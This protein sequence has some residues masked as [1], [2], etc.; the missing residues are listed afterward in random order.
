MR[1][2]A[3]DKDGHPLHRSSSLSNNDH[4]RLCFRHLR[5]RCFLSPFFAEYLPTTGFVTKPRILAIASAHHARLLLQD[6]TPCLPTADSHSQVPT[7][8]PAVAPEQSEFTIR[9][10]LSYL[11]SAGI[12]SYL[13]P[14]L[15]LLFCTLATLPILPVLRTT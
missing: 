9:P 3:D 10:L 12:H 7:S 2:L 8:I 4:Q 11:V 14:S 5:L 6:A 13:T 1:R 15:P